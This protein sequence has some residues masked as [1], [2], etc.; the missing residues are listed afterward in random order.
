MANRTALLLAALTL[1][2]CKTATCPRGSQL[3]GDLCKPIPEL[4][5]NVDQDR[6][7]TIDEGL[8]VVCG[9]DEGAC[10]T[11]VSTCRAG[12][13]SDCEDGV[14]PVTELCGDEEDNDCD[15]EVDEATDEVCNAVD[16]D[17]DGM[18]DEGLFAFGDIQGDVE[19]RFPLSDGSLLYGYESGNTYRLTKLGI[20]GAAVGEPALTDEQIRAYARGPFVENNIVVFSKVADTLQFSRYE[21][22]QDTVVLEQEWHDAPGEGGSIH[23]EDAVRWGDSRVLALYTQ[24]I[25]VDKVEM[26]VWRIWDVDLARPSVGK[27]P[28]DLSTDLNASALDLASNPSGGLPFLAHREI[29]DQQIRISQIDTDTGTLVNTTPVA[30]GSPT[31]LRAGPDGNVWIFYRDVGGQLIARALDPESLGCPAQL[32]PCETTINSG[33]TVGAFNVA[34]GRN[35]WWIVYGRGRNL[36]VDR[37]SMDL[38]VVSATPEPLDAGSDIEDVSA[39]TAVAGDTGLY[40]HYRRDRGFVGSYSRAITVACRN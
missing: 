31:L 34:L 21:T 35:E 26:N 8:T 14:E 12:E 10:E 13:W 4:C 32:N 18:I 3:V 17:C 7:G 33:G 30:V 6:D 29:D 20:D 39:L 25:T 22:S 5:D 40:V 19:T 37:V 27:A 15:G 2:G 1:G 23:Y 16:D 38:R 28:V 11:G 36:H 9:S 24:T